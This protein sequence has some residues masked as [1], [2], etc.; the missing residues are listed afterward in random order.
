MGISEP[1]PEKQ[2]RLHF[3]VGSL[4]CLGL[5]N[6]VNAKLSAPDGNTTNV[7]VEW[8]FVA[9]LGMLGGIK[10]TSTSLLTLS[11][12][13]RQRCFSWNANKCRNV[14]GGF[15]SWGRR[16]LINLYQP[17]MAIAIYSEQMLL[18][19]SGILFLMPIPRFVERYI[20]LQVRWIYVD[21]PV[22]TFPSPPCTSSLFFSTSGRNFRTSTAAPMPG[23]HRVA[24]I[25]VPFAIERR[26]SSK[27][28][29]RMTP[30]LVTMSKV[31][32]QGLYFIFLM[33]FVD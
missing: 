33:H 21:K 14:R 18:G 12:S 19:N 1:S 24:Q 6:L 30:P 32:V 29:L 13:A 16:A 8:T 9:S 4:L 26:N 28:Y 2:R 31:P 22:F 5:W 23:A 7:R 15:L 27:C 25:P 17:P 10:R 20:W 11:I 3:R